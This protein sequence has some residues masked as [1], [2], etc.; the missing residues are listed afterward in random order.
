MASTPFIFDQFLHH[1]DAHA[2]DEIAQALG[3]YFAHDMFI[4][5]LDPLTEYC[6]SHLY[7]HFRQLHRVNTDPR[8][9]KYNA[10]SHTFIDHWRSWYS[11]SHVFNPHLDEV[12]AL[13]AEQHDVFSEVACRANSDYRAY[14]YDR[15]YAPLRSIASGACIWSFSPYFGNTRPDPETLAQDMQDVVDDIDLT[16][17]PELN[18]VVFD[19]SHSLYNR[20]SGDALTVAIFGNVTRRELTARLAH[21]D[22]VYMAKRKGNRTADT[23][24]FA[25]YLIEA[26]VDGTY[27]NNTPEADFVKDA[28]SGTEL[29]AMREITTLKDL[30]DHLEIRDASEGAMKAG[31]AVWNNYRRQLKDSSLT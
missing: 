8:L 31:K 18:V 13:R 9:D 21:I 30:R 2:A 19:F 27:D 26:R 17:M 15:Q 4:C 20:T 6:G 23:Y 5:D 25:E 22:G 3:T 24:S 7:A 10:M 11:V 28:S 14:D 16:F 29:G 12:Q 1:K